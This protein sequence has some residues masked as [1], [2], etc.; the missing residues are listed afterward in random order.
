MKRPWLFLI[1]AI[2]GCATAPET[3]DTFSEATEAEQKLDARKLL[4]EREK[5]GNLDRAVRV[6]EWQVAQ[7]PK[8]E[9]I[10]LLAAEAY[11]RSL[12]DMG[13]KKKKDTAKAKR[14]LTQGAL[15][16]QAAIDLEPGN[17][18]AQYWRAC[19]LLHEA[20]VGSSLGK[21]KEA[22]VLLEKAD[23]ADPKIDD[24]GP[25]RMKGRV[26]YEMPP[27][28]GGSLSKAVTNYKR[29]LSVA[30]NTI[31][32]HLW[33]GEAYADGKKPDLAR[34]EWETVVASK[35]RPGHEKEDG[36]D[37]KAA[38]EKLKALGTK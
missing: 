26:Y 30:P 15:H 23:A 14:L 33:L 31:T 4:D 20:D 3:P 1:L 22:L 25:S 9:K 12:E 10:R 36:A 5:D 16:A 28:V 32:T 2:A 27:L 35:P 24:G 38:E 34:K 13:D 8:D 17:A 21:A 11:S 6:A 7:K 19:I 18:T 29:S 37:I